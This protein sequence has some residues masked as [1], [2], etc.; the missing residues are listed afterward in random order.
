MKVTDHAFHL[1]RLTDAAS[2]LGTSTEIA[3]WI[4]AMSAE[5]DRL[6]G[7]GVRL[8]EAAL[9]WPNRRRIAKANEFCAAV[10]PELNRAVAT[11]RRVR[12]MFFIEPPSTAV[13]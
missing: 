1:S 5:I 9:R 6:Q 7:N 8:R 4:D 11:L 10:E 12:A 2:T 13:N 3:D